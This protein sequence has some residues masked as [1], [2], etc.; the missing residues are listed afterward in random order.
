MTGPLE[1]VQDQNR[2]FRRS[3]EQEKNGIFSVA[4]PSWGNTPVVWPG[5]SLR[6]PGCVGMACRGFEDSTPATRHRSL[7]GQYGLE[8]RAIDFTVLIL[9]NSLV[10]TIRPLTRTPNRQW[11]PNSRL[12]FCP[13]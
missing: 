8:A 2:V 10:R 13:V 1:L 7:L 6:N 9:D 5:L 3:N 11:P 12:S 4:W